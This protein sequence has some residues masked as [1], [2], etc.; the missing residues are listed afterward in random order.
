[1]KMDKNT[2]VILGGVGSLLVAIITVSSYINMKD[3][4]TFLKENAKLENQIKTI[5]LELKKHQLT[6]M[7]K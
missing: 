7:S 3:H 5:D 1:M 2:I 6:T 4:R